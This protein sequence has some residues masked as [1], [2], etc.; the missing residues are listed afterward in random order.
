MQVPNGKVSN[1][2][3]RTWTQAAYTKYCFGEL[4][5]GT[6]CVLEKTTRETAIFSTFSGICSKEVRG[7]SRT[8]LLSSVHTQG[9]VSLLPAYQCSEFALESWSSNP[10]ILNRNRLPSH[11]GVLH[12]NFRKVN[13][14]VVM[15]TILWP[16][17]HRVGPQVGEVVLFM[18]I[19]FGV[20][21]PPWNLRVLTFTM[22]LP[23]SRPPFHSLS[24]CA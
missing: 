10:F 6:K 15:V 3:K 14:T 18:F 11:V 1:I 24:L 2:S 9:N 4:S 5:P 20:H 16:I 8:N 19:T 21:P 7:Q 13:A 12:T 17:H 22:V 23:P